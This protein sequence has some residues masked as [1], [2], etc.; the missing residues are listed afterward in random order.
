M[1]KHYERFKILK[2]K[3]ILALIKNTGGRKCKTKIED[4]FLNISTT[5]LRTFKEKGC[6]CAICGLKGTYFAI[7]RHLDQKTYHLN[8]YGINETGEEIML[9]SDHIIS[10]AHGGDK[11]SIN[12]RQTLCQ[13]CNEKKA[14]KV[15]VIDEKGI[16]FVDCEE[17]VIKKLNYKFNFID[18]I[19]KEFNPETCNLRSNYRSCQECKMY[20]VCD[21]LFNVQI[22]VDQLKV[23][24]EVSN[25]TG[26]S[27]DL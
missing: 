15:E 6:D 17:T 24:N 26:N 27:K 7:E 11:N 19:L 13:I 1:Q 3:Q 21:Q 4:K 9:T 23:E 20:T 2:L 18:T 12:N 25:E 16:Y 14:D 5:R 22:I 10:K 8:L